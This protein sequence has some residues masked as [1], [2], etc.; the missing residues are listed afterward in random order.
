MLQL[1]FCN[2]DVRSPESI[3]AYSSAGSDVYKRTAEGEDEHANAIDEFDQFLW[4]DQHATTLTASP[5]RL[6]SLY[7]EDMSRP[8]WRIVSMT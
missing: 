1:F 2:S 6:V 5:P 8:V 3:L 7:L 4:P